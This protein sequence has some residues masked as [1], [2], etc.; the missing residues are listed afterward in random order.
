MARDCGEE[1]IE[2]LL[3]E[4]TLIA[5]GLSYEVINRNKLVNDTLA[6]DSNPWFR[7]LSKVLT[8]L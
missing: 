5:P 1:G 6:D 3:K 7:G 8:S 2:R 4:W